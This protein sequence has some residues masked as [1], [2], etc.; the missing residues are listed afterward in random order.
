MASLPSGGERSVLRHTNVLT[1]VP[2]ECEQVEWGGG[3]EW[4]SSTTDSDGFPVHSAAQL[5]LAHMVAAGHLSDGSS[6]TTKEVRGFLEQAPPLLDAIYINDRRAAWSNGRPNAAPSEEARSAASCRWKSGSEACWVS[7]HGRKACRQMDALEQRCRQHPETNGLLL[8]QTAAFEATLAEWGLL[9]EAGLGVALGLTAAGKPPRLWFFLPP[10]ADTGVWVLEGAH[11]C[12]AAASGAHGML[13]VSTLIQETS[14]RLFTA[15]TA[16]AAQNTVRHVSEAV[17]AGFRVSDPFAT[18]RGG[19]AGG[20][21]VSAAFEAWR[22]ETATAEQRDLVERVLAGSAAGVVAMAAARQA[23]DTNTATREQQQSVQR[24]RDGWMAGVV[25]M[26]DARQAVDTNTATHEQQQSVQRQRD[27]GMAGVKAR[28]QWASATGVCT[29]CG[30]EVTGLCGPDCTMR[31]GHCRTRSVRWKWP[32]GRPDRP[33]TRAWTGMTDD[34][35]AASRWAVE[36]IWFGRRTGCGGGVEGE[37]AGKGEECCEEA[38]ATAA[39][40]DEGAHGVDACE[41]GSDEGGTD[42]AVA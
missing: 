5:V 23:V 37:G 27:G 33:S 2:P 10:A 41:V 40:D 24:W 29:R 28:G 4:F 6:A 38:A 1:Y 32:G 20:A 8:D 22:K 3:A 34:E 42:A 14:A 35:K 15:P 18:L 16:A 39:D 25:A 11:P 17:D 26:A 9:L 12:A 31:C 13:S 21:L 7:V 36:G 30:A 19:A